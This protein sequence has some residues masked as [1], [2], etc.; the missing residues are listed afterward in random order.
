MPTATL[1]IPL[2]P[3]AT[4]PTAFPVPKPDALCPECGGLEPDLDFEPV[5]M[6][7]GGSGLFPA[8]FRLPPA[9]AHRYRA[10]RYEPGLRRLRVTVAVKPHTKAE[11]D[12]YSV[13]EV[14]CDGPGRVFICAKLGTL[15]RTHEVY[16]GPDGVSCSCEGGV[17]VTTAKANQRAHDAG[18]EVF[19]GYG[20][21]H[22][23]A[24][25][26]LLKNGWMDIQEE[27]S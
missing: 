15:D 22:S 17:Y 24:L 5:C 4:E 27:R 20:C 1:D 14:P 23:D 8:L 10:V 7:C 26:A 2:P 16:V 21:R 18:E 12:E 9:R 25:A 11:S 6:S 3:G 19:P 13:Q